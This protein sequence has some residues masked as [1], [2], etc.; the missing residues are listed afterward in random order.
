MEM[1]VRP[2]CKGFMLKG[3]SL[4]V[5]GEIVGDSFTV[6]VGP[7]V[8][9]LPTAEVSVD[10]SGQPFAYVEE[11]AITLPFG[12]T[13][14]IAENDPEPDDPPNGMWQHE[15]ALLG[16]DRRCSVFFGHDGDAIGAVSIEPSEDEGEEDELDG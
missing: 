8:I 13:L 5:V 9:T 10:G 3:L 4:E 15:L 11:G 7:L 6:K 2:F 14:E 1:K 16:E 12:F